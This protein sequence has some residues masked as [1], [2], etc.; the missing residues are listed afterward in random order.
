M[1][2]DFTSLPISTT[3]Y[4][5]LTSKSILVGSDQF[6]LQETGAGT[7]LKATLANLLIK[8]CVLFIEP[9]RDGGISFVR[10]FIISDKDDC[11]VIRKN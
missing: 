1:T 11:S 8:E 3:D 4:D 6:P 9:K 10:S 7:T 2:A 5:E